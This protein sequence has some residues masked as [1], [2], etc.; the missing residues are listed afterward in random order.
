MKTYANVVPLSHASFSG[1]MPKK[2]KN[3]EVRTREYLTSKEI[4]KLIDAA[5]KVGRH[6]HRD[7]TLILV[8]YRHGLRVSELIALRWDQVNL[9][10]GLIH[11]NRL[12]MVPRQHIHSGAP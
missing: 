8:A 1:K 2:P 4:D 12:K 5:R 9:S 7:A 3:K 11:I 10:E 6:G